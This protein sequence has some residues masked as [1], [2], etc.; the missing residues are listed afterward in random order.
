MPIDIAVGRD[1]F[2][3]VSCDCNGSVHYFI[4]E[5]YGVHFMKNIG[6]KRRSFLAG[7]ASL[8][9]STVLASAA[10]GRNSAPSLDPRNDLPMIYRKIRY[11][12]GDEVVLWW[13]EGM[14]YG[15]RNASFRPLYG[16]ETCNWNRVKQL[17]DGGFSVTVLECAFY[18]DPASGE[19]LRR[20]LNPY[21]GRM[22][23]IPYAAVGPATAQYAPNSDLIPFSE[24]GGSKITMKTTNG[25]VTILDDTLW[26]RTSNDFQLMSKAGGSVRQVNEWATYVARASEVANRGVKCV[27]PTVDLVEV[28]TWPR[29]LEMADQPG[30][31]MGQISGRKMRRFEE[32]PEGFRRRLAEVFPAIAKDPL[33]ALDRPQA[34]LVH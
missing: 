24:I 29:W 11:S 34:E 12:A 21:T 25:P 31:L 20:F 33:A 22:V 2:V 3:H 32:M 23:E 19:V 18:T 10:H 1:G 17:P 4:L 16:V 15:Q 13:F 5:K 6:L 26:L 7:A 28:T 9:A 8:S 27:Y 30:A 14:K